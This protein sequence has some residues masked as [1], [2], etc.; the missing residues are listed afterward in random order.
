MKKLLSPFMILCLLALFVGPLVACGP[1]DNGGDD[2]KM[3]DAASTAGD[4]MEE[5]GDEMMDK[6][7]DAMDEAGDKMDD[8]MDKADDAMDDAKK[9]DGGSM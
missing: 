3:E 8:A 7:D 6:A 2:T 5:A 9:D 1:A 4:Q